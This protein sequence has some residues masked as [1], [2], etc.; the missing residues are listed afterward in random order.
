[1]HKRNHSKSEN[2]SNHS[3]DNWL[4][5]LSLFCPFNLYEAIEGDLLEQFDVDIE[6]VGLKRAKRRFIWN[7]VRFFRPGIILRNKFSPAL[8]QM[9]MLQNYL[10]VMLRNMMKRKAY[11]TITIFGL[12]AGLT[13]SMLIAVFVWQELNVNHQLKDVDRLY[14]LEQ[15]QDNTSGVRF[16]APAE[17]PK[18]MREQYPS[19]IE[20]YYRFWDRSVKVSKGDKHFLVQSIVGDSTLLKMF[21]FPVLYGDVNSALAQPYTVAITEK[22]ALQFFNKTDVVGESLVLSSGTAEKK[23]YVITAVLPPLERNSVSDLV[24]INAQVF[25]SIQNAPDFRLPDPEGWV[26][27]MVSYLKV[28]PNVTLSEAE[29]VMNMTISKHAPDSIKSSLKM[30]LVGLDDYYLVT[31]NGAAKKMIVTMSGIAGFIL[32]LAIINFVNISMGSA[33]VRLKEIGIRKVIGGIKRQLIFQF[34]SESLLLTL[35]AGCVSFLL[36]ELLRPTFEGLFSTSLV[37]IWNLDTTFWQL[38]I[39]LLIIIGL[40]AGIYP[41]FFMSS[42]KITESLRGKVKRA[43]GNIPLPKILV[44]LQFLVAISIFICA[45]VITE[46]V[47]YFLRKDL[48]Y[49]K[50]FVLT[51]SSVPRVW[52]EEGLNQMNA[53]KTEFLASPYV[54]SASLSWEV[55]NGNSG[56]NANIYREGSEEEKAVLMPLLKT[57]EDYHK[58]YGLKLTSGRFFFSDAETWQPNTLVINES[59]AK[60]LGAGVG[61]RLRIQGAGEVVFTV[62]G[63][64]DDFHFTSL[65]EPVKPLAFIHTK[66]STFFRFFSFRLKPGNLAGSV[67]EVHKIWKKVFPEDPFEYAFMDEQLSRLYKAELQLKKASAVATVLMLIIV[68]TGIIGVVSLSVSRRTKEI[69]IRK[70]LGA[71]VSNILVM[72]SKE[73]VTLSAVAFAVSIPLAY[74]FVNNW[75]EGF[76]YHIEMR[77]WMFALPGIITVVITLC[78]VGW[79]SLKTAL[80]NPTNTLKYE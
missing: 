23:E 46:Q 57:D 69:G 42:Y 4:Y 31:N 14:I 48:G 2:H 12:T 56:G 24:N 50:S 71:T 67:A 60:A 75:L 20:S 65:R 33:T 45:I 43:M 30:K 8:N 68:L 35:A 28:A 62:R 15:D 78:I 59:A 37:S 51:V 34:L 3:T 64:V 21:G 7:V 26:Q 32:L 39:V 61:D 41:A 1:M 76:S 40:S 18:A 38:C 49:D 80:L 77:W 44:T 47:T 11:S 5:L 66:E 73:Y 27:G 63:I 36:Y 74:Y 79:Q 16:F 53:A 25:L 58:V 70:V 6:A 72:I 52:T 10:K 22:I 9:P 17:L 29:R 13:F 19:V 55:P 54:E